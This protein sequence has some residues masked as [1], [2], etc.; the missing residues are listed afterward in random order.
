MSGT[1]L[2]RVARDLAR[3]DAL[4]AEFGVLQSS[5][6][7]RVAELVRAAG[8]TVT[9][10]GRGERRV[11]G[12]GVSDE[13]L[14]RAR[15]CWPDG[16]WVAGVEQVV[17]GGD[18]LHLSG[19]V[20]RAALAVADTHRELDDRALWERLADVSLQLRAALAQWDTL[21]DDHVAQMLAEALELDAVR[22]ITLRTDGDGLW[23]VDQLNFDEGAVG[24]EHR[25]ALWLMEDLT[26]SDAQ[27]GEHPGAPA[28]LVAR[29]EGISVRLLNSSC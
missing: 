20:G 9:V 26:M 6:R 8:G 13:L 1:L 16:L 14:F 29:A 24:D 28:E 25:Q 10:T 23:A 18:G 3:L 22:H 27:L 2:E 5:A 15:R 12:Q 21:L 11:S 17:L 7:H 4:H 19:P